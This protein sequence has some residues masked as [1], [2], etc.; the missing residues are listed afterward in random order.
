MRE[1]LLGA[2]QSGVFE[3]LWS[4]KIL[5]EWHH[6][7]GKLGPAEAAYCAGE[8]A[9]LRAIFPKAT[10]PLTEAQQSRF[11]LPDAGDIHVLAA[12]VVGHADGI[13]TLNNKDFPV[14]VLAEEGLSRVNPDALLLGFW[15]AHPEKIEQVVYDVLAEARR[16]SGTDWTLR[17]LMKKARMPRLGKALAGAERAP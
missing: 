7:A 15:Q 16:L 6:T 9:R 4:Q 2:A 1:M 10:V 11:W 3:P 17:G 5:E 8:I 14:G 12:A 13:V